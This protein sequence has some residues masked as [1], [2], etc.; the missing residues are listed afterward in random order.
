MIGIPR[1]DYYEAMGRQRNLEIKIEQLCGISQSC[2]TL[3]VP[4]GL[5]FATRNYLDA[6]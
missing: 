6:K 2:L 5:R 1:S 3:A 4:T